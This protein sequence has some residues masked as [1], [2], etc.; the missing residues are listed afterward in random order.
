[1]SEFPKFTTHDVVRYPSYIPD[2]KAAGKDGFSATMLKKTLPFT[3]NVLTDMVNRLLCDRV[4]P[5]CWKS[6]RV[7]PIL[8]GCSIESPSNF[9]PT[10]IL[11]V[12][13]QLSE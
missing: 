10:F 11:P 6:A 5:S 2:K 9:R 4:S 8:K 3:L 12:L 1:M 13:S 7:T